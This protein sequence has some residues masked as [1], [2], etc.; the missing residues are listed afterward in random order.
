VVLLEEGA[1]HLHAQGRGQ[2]LHKQSR[3]VKQRDE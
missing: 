2:C 1:A 3:F